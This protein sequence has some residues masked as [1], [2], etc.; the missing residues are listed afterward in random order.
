MLLN[1]FKTIIALLPAG[2]AL[3]VACLVS[4]IPENQG[5]WTLIV[6]GLVIL[7]A[8]L[9]A[10]FVTGAITVKRPSCSFPLVSVLFAVVFIVYIGAFSLIY[11][12]A[13]LTGILAK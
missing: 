12:L 6:W 9:A 13:L 8:I 3:G 7:G 11:W 10:S 2:A 4:Q 5:L 1:S